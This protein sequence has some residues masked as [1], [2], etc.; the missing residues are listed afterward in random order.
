MLFSNMGMLVKK[1]HQMVGWRDK[2]INETSNI[3]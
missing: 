2:G 3:I 1:S